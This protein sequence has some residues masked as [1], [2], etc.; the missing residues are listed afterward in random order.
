MVKTNSSTSSSEF[1]GLGKLLLKIACFS[2][3]LIAIVVINYY[4][5]P[6][7][8]YHGAAIYDCYSEALASGKNVAGF[9]NMDERI[10]KARTLEAMKTAPDVAIF[11]SSRAMMLGEQVFPGLRVFNSSVSGGVL[12]DYIGLFYQYERKDSFPK[13][14]VLGIDPWLFNDNVVEARWESIASD[15]KK[16]LP[17][18]GYEAAHDDE[19]SFIP[20][21][22]LNII[23]LS[24]LSK[25]V[26]KL[27]ESKNKKKKKK[28][29]SACIVT[30]A[31]TH[32]DFAMVLHDGRHVYDKAYR[33]KTVE[34][35]E[36]EAVKYA[37]QKPVYHLENFRAIS[38]EKLKLLADFIRYMRG[39][40]IHV[41][42][43]LDPYHPT[44]FELLRQNPVTKIIT[45]TETV[46]RDFA[47]KN[48]IPVLGSY[49]PTRYDLPASLFYDGMHTK[50]EADSKIFSK[51]AEEV[52][53]FLKSGNQ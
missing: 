45:E 2:P 40:K 51:Q 7:N 6:A 34:A 3:V 37:T 10:V 5:D 8:I 25:S 43:Y 49:D 31:V 30:D 14:V 36:S 13:Y 47:A 35:V 26:E 24:Y 32:D 42:F 16:M 29:Q 4:G 20:Q 38:E 12:K 9:S 50:P 1:P 15:Y 11:G 41:M 27:R 28:G 52:N 44:T 17:L 53:N 46:V 23:S 48:G 33:E 21:K 19:L 18:L 39:K 22:V